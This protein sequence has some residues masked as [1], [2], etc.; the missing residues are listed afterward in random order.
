M[1]CDILIKNG[2][3]IDTMRNIDTI[4]D[5]G[6]MDGRIINIEAGES[7][8][9]NKTIDASGYLVLPGLIDFHGHFNFDGSSIGAIPSLL[10]ASGVTSV[11]DAGSCG[12]YNF[13][14]FYKNTIIHSPVL[15]KAF[16]SC[17]SMGLG[18]SG[19]NENFDKTL[20]DRKRISIILAKFAN[21]ILGLKIRCSI[22]L[23]KSVEPL[24]EV[25]AIAEELGIGVCVHTT[26]PPCSILE[27]ANLLRKGDIFCHVYHGKGDTILD[28]NDII[29]KEIWKARERGVV[30]DV[31]NGNNHFS[32]YV[33]SKSIEQGFCPDVISTDM[34]ND[35]LY[36]GLKARSLPFVM[37][38]FLSL[39]M[40][41][42]DV[43]RCVTETPAKLMKMEGQ[44]GTLSPG[45][46]ANVAIMNLID[47]E[48]SSVDSEG[49]VYKGNKMFIPQMTI[50]NGEIAYCQ[51]YFNIA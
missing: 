21:I 23:V 15:V 45:A 47:K 6:I 32:N 2:H 9:S 16:L 1:K 50:L 42:F 22:P 14:S 28:E 10:P 8:H 41:L 7:M 13:P 33:C 48:F 35:K 17:Y 4:C 25:I 29:K 18:G 5:I 34:T 26:N 37:S 20:F 38:K 49:N 44:I 19:I 43:V 30:F 31:A 36:Y 51:E 39:G 3:V 12:C 46:F 11:V 24:N 27:I 40:T